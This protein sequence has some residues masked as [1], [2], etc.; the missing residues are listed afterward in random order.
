VRDN[1][2]GDQQLTGND[3]DLALDG[4][5]FFILQND[6]GQTFYTRNGR[7]V[8]N[9]DDEL[10]TVGQGLKVMT[11][12]AS[13]QLVPVTFGS[14]R[15]SPAKATTEITLDNLLSTADDED[16]TTLDIK[17]FDALG[18]SHA[19]KLAIKKKTE[20]NP[21]LP[22]GQIAFSVTATEGDTD[23]GTTTLTFIGTTPFDSPA[24]IELAL[25]DTDP[26]TVKLNFDRVFLLSQG[27]SSLRVSEQDGRAAG[28]VTA[29]TFDEKGVLKLTYSNGEKADGPTLA[30]ARID[31]EDG[32]VEQGAS[33][34]SYRGE[35]SVV[36]REP[37]DDLKVVPQSLELSN[38]DLTTEFSQLILMQRGYQAASQVI[39]T[40]NDM[41]QELLQMRGRG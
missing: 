9:A 10:V 21:P 36:L 39:S 15:V 41:M 34:F 22:T 30:L 4:E 38:V 3:T 33:L 17:V 32:L 28:T 12:N 23:I 27:S 40:A 19:I 11:R 35:K 24:S 8:F 20:N 25:K 2:A 14:L 26:A 7:F 1:R 37:G 5:G 13:G 6:E 29:K 31:D 16:G 18:T